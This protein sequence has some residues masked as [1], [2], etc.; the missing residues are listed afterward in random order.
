MAFRWHLV[1]LQSS[2]AEESGLLH[3]PLFEVTYFIFPCLA[4]RKPHVQT[5]SPGKTYRPRSCKILNRRLVTSFHGLP[6]S[7]GNGSMAQSIETLTSSVLGTFTF[8]SLQPPTRRA[9]PGSYLHRL[10]LHPYSISNS[11]GLLS[12]PSLLSFWNSH[13]TGSLTF[14]LWTPLPLLPSV[15]ELL[16][17]SL[18][19][20]L[21]PH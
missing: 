3:I 17:F 8:P 2:I 4:I 14:R 5:S 19:P 13:Q 12:N 7:P 9:T 11:R 20:L 16:G 10:L 15:S 6:L 18:L 21:L 1:L